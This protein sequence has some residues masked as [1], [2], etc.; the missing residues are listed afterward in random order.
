[1]RSI[2]SFSLTSSIAFG[3]A[4]GVIGSQ[5]VIAQ[6][7]TEQRNILVTADLKGIDG[8]EIRMWRT[9]LA[10]GVA[11]AKHYHLGTECL[12]VLEGALDLEK[13]GEATAHL[14]AGDAHCVPP[15]TVLLPRNASNTQA[16]KSL[17]VM[18]TPKGEPIAVPVQ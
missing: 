7:R 3:A 11:G 1:M 10:P 12:Y 13:Q 9:D 17:V 2:L 15:K 16:Y 5:L 8:Y 6:H 4:L 14:K 18:I